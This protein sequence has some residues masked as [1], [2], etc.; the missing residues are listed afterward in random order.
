MQVY[1]LMTELFGIH[2]NPYL[3]TT[4]SKGDSNLDAYAGLADKLMMMTID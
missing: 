3:S 2:T 1:N 4:A